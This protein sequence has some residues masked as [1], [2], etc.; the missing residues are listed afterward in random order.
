M[1]GWKNSIPTPLFY[2]FRPICA[3]R[4]KMFI[5]FFPP[6]FSLFE[7]HRIPLLTLSQIQTRKAKF[8]SK[9]IQ[10]KVLIIQAEIRRCRCQL[11]CSHLTLL[12]INK[13]SFAFSLRPRIFR[14]TLSKNFL[15][16]IKFSF[17][18][19]EI[20]SK[21]FFDE[22]TWIIYLLELNRCSENRVISS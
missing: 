8:V 21:V 16:D 9:V 14:I 10:C 17:S 13:K 15:P 11:Y 4:P 3:H 7:S 19:L 22:L 20:I 5:F 6:L 1:Y 2:Y 12:S 18:M